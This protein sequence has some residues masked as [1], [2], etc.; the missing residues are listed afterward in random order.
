MKK[1][2]AALLVALVTVAASPMGMAQ[3][4]PKI[5]V[6]DLKKVFD[7]Y[8]KT[9]QADTNLK[10]QAAE[11]DKQRKSMLDAYER[12]SSEYK[13][14]EA[15]LNDQAVAA[16]EREK[17][18]KT[19]E[20]KLME[21]REVEQSVQQ[22]DRTA[23]TQIGERQR[24]MRDSILKEIKEAISA[25]T[26]SAGYDMIIDSAAESTNGTPVVMFWN[27]TGDI[28]E[29]ILSHLNANAPPEPAPAPAASPAE[30]K[31]DK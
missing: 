22:F 2:F 29:A 31:K 15:T 6:I 21:I 10:S 28:T 3:T 16:E 5:G 17:R 12:L 20:G 11:L 23:R 25:K 26:K 27:G 13:K 18:K 9:K 19:A 8:W 7:G 24:Q 1:L 30:K 14:I 4:S